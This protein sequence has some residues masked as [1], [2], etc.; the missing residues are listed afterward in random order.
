LGFN[1]MVK[2][3]TAS[4][5]LGDTAAGNTIDRSQENMMGSNNGALG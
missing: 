5:P 2:N 4:G 1:G 3:T